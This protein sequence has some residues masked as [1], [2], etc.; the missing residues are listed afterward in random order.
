MQHGNL[1][2]TKFCFLSCHA[3]FRD[4]P[5][6]PNDFRLIIYHYYYYQSRDYV[7]SFNPRNIVLRDSLTKFSFSFSQFFDKICVV[8]LFFN[9]L[10]G[11]VFVGIF[12]RSFRKFPDFFCEW[13]TMLSFSETVSWN[14][15]IFFISEFSKNSRQNHSC[16]LW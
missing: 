1:F 16:S 4:I 3:S 9:F 10:W 6:S 8:Y 5:L 13:F 12:S 11:K 14:S 7:P 2:F 15:W